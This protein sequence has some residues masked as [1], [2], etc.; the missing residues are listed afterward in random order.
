MTAC[1]KLYCEVD[2]E[3]NGGGFCEN[4][5]FPTF[6]FHGTNWTVIANLETTGIVT[7][8]RGNCFMKNWCKNKDCCDECRCRSIHVCSRFL[9]SSRTN[10]F[11]LTA[12]RRGARSPAGRG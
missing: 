3:T 7:S 12:T 11:R 8:R 6:L 2:R 5:G 10:R 1:L 4:S 9:K